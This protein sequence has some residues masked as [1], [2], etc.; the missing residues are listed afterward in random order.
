LRLVTAVLGEVSDDWESGKTYLSIP[1][2]LAR[3]P[4]QQRRG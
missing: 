3:T 1:E 2:K 4:E